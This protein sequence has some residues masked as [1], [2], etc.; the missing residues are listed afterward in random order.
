MYFDS[1]IMFFFCLDFPYDI[2][3]DGKCFSFLECLP[4]FFLTLGRTKRGTP[5]PEVFWIFFLNEQTS[6]PDVFSSYWFI[7]RA[8]FETEV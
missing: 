3:L 8:H 4:D 5:R 2:Y 1:V 7:P 6:L